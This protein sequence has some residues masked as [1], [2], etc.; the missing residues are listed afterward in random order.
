MASRLAQSTAVG[1]FMM[2]SANIR[3]ENSK[4]I[5]AS[6]QDRYVAKSVREQCVEAWRPIPFRAQIPEEDQDFY[7]ALPPYRDPHKFAINWDIWTDYPYRM[8]DLVDGPD[9]TKGFGRLPTKGTS[10]ATSAGTA[11]R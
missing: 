3:K 6:A 1:V 11:S 5:I 10:P 9:P 8:A 7:N 4:L 2:S